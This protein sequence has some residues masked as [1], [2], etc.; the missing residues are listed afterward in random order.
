MA[1]GPQQD[2]LL[3]AEPPLD[4]GHV[5][6]GAEVEVTVGQLAR[7]GGGA[8]GRASSF[9]VVLGCVRLCCKLF[10]RCTVGLLLLLL[11]RGCWGYRGVMWMDNGWHELDAKELTI[12]LEA[13][14]RRRRRAG[15]IILHEVCRQDEVQDTKQPKEVTR[16]LAH[17]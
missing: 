3:E 14:G 13:L 6:V 7:S 2:V 15:V 1:Q 16:L 9:F 8:F 5:G 11:C 4:R 12:V 10:C 17:A